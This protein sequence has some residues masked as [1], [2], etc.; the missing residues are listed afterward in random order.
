MK[1]KVIIWDFD[2]PIVDSRGLALELTQ[3][4]FHDIDED[5][6][7]NLF[8][9]NIFNELSKL[10]KKDISDS[11]RSSFKEN[12]YW[13]KKME[14][15]PVKGITEVIIELAR[16]FSMVVNSSSATNKIDEYLKKNN[17]DKFFQKIYGSEIKSKV[18]KFETILKDFE[19]VPEDCVLITDT[20]GDVLEAD[21]LHIPSIVVPWGYQLREHFNSVSEKVIFVDAP[22]EV[23]GAIEKHFTAPMPLGK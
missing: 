9:G 4:E 8:N 13:P 1:K 6:H 17:L 22:V 19:V 5:I 15:P 10:R 20:L 16:N 11:E 7:R 14:L 18:E 3:Y 23:P 2:G 21:I 12:Y